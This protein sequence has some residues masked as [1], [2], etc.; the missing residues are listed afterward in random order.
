[1]KLRLASFL[2]ALP[3][4]SL[5]VIAAAHSASKSWRPESVAVR[6]MELAKEFADK[7]LKL[8]SPVF[9]RVYK[10]TSEM[11]LWVQQGP[12]YELFKIYKICR[13]SGGLGP[14]FYE[15]DRQSP[16][17]LYRITTSDLIVNRRWDRAMNIN[18]PN[19]F[20]H[21]N[22]RGGSSILI[23][24]G[25]GSIGC[26]AI[27][28]Q[29]VEEVYGA[30]RA[31]LRGS[32]AYVPVLTLP[33][34]FSALAPEKEDTLHMSEFWSDLRRADLLFERDR[35][36]PTA[37]ICDGRYYFADRRGDRRRHA[38]HLPGC[39]PLDNPAGMRNAKNRPEPQKPVV[40]A[41]TQ[42]PQ[43]AGGTQEAV[44]T[45][46]Q[47]GSPQKAVET[48]AQAASPQRAVETAVQTGSPRRAFKTVAHASSP[49]RMQSRTKHAALKSTP[50]C[51]KKYPR[52]RY[53][54]GPEPKR[55]QSA[56]RRSNVLRVKHHTARGGKLRRL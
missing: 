55:T 19:N 50:S 37:W 5:T 21:L 13:W 56:A 49:A 1:M 52:C 41:S 38:V 33:F 46:A 15:G 48:V 4:I 12:R 31:A 43:Q 2:L 27:Q 51:P 30:V 9:L 7:G 42:A 53:F 36:P 34:R 3:V 47:A 23:H 8:G 28:N 32:Q 17:G 35:L 45:V 44:E 54:V 26:F 25:C 16:E 24:G 11:E 40:E 39:K 18:Y 10:Q 29:N 14:K 6:E 22:G 20:D